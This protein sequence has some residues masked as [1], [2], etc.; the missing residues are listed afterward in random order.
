MN[1]EEGVEVRSG[2]LT[3]LPFLFVFNFSRQQ[4]TNKSFS[5]CIERTSK[6]V[7]KACLQDPQTDNVIT[8]YFTLTS[9]SFG[10]GLCYV[11]SRFSS[12]VSFYFI[13]VLLLMTHP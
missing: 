8:S 7:P 6:S 1:G 11:H 2:L 3:P 9:L 12:F 13:F 5:T 4:K 10:S